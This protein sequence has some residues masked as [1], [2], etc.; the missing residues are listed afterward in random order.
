MRGEW[1]VLGS[2]FEA[3]LTRNIPST[4]TPCHHDT[5]IHSLDMHVSSTLCEA[6]ASRRD[7]LMATFLSEDPEKTGLVTKA[8]WAEVMQD[9][10]GLTMD[11]E[12]VMNKVTEAPRP[13]LFI[14]K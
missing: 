1:W 5:T 14:K 9:V 13:K 8:A 11:W 12:M 10:I 2:Y 6:V 7:A 3:R 4:F